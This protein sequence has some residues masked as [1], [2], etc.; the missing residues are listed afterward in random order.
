[1]Y[2]SQQI[3]QKEETAG[4][5]P[6]SQQ[7]DKNKNHFQ[8]SHLLSMPYPFPY[9]NFLLKLIF[10]PLSTISSFQNPSPSSAH[11]PNPFSK[12]KS[13]RTK[14]N[15][16]QEVLMYLAT[17]TWFLLYFHKIESYYRILIFQW[18]FSLTLKFIVILS[19]Q[20]SNEVGMIFL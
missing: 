6:G 17:S 14:P 18:I 4:H 1:M 8:L 5:K 19:S 15:K 12:N 2:F 20:K 11:F 16:S 9:L 13:L 10:Q 3:L 7:Q